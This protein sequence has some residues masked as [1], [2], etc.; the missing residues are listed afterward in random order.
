MWPGAPGST[1]RTKYDGG[2]DHL[3]L[4]AKNKTGYQNLSS[5]VSLGWTEGFYYKP[6]I[7]K[8][9]LRK[10]HEGLIATSACLGGEVAQTIM[11]SGVEEGEKVI[12]EYREIFGDDFYLELMR[13]PSGDPETDQRV[14]KDQVYVNESFYNWR[15][16]RY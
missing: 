6:R 13:H 16:A 8:E 14:Y 10:Y 1:R 7:D 2:G 5:I 11:N 9:L 12:L 4:L 3:I 15:K